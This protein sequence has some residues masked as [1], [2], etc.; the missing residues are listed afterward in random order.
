MNYKR[1]PLVSLWICAYRGGKVFLL[2]RRKK[3]KISDLK[4]AKF[5]HLVIK[6]KANF[7]IF[8]E[9]TWMNFASVPHE[10]K[11]CVEIYWIAISVRIFFAAFNECRNSFCSLKAFLCYHQLLRDTNSMHSV[12]VK[13][14]KK[15]DRHGNRTSSHFYWREN[16]ETSHFWVLIK[17]LHKSSRVRFL[18]LIKCINS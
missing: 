11:S 13:A 14:E 6:F 16:A 1:Q 2:K 18:L 15:V 12:A 17:K 9:P 8:A 10:K 4:S 3:C 7:L 5:N